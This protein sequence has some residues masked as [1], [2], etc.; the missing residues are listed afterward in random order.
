MRQNWKYNAFYSF[1][2]LLVVTADQY[3]KIWVR[4]TIPMH[5]TRAFIPR[6]VA[7]TYEQNT[8]AAFSIFRNQ[9]G[10]LT[11]ISAIAVVALIFLLFKKNFFSSELERWA[12]VFILAGALGNLIDRAL[13]GYVVDMFSLQFMRFA[14]F[15]IADISVCVGG[16]LLILAV[17]LLTSKQNKEKKND[18]DCG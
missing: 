8:G 12:I 1:V 6:V 7:L 15:N 16:G 5:E 3:L 13:L 10:I 18:V 4:E 17:I 11:V 14:I 2:V 9:T